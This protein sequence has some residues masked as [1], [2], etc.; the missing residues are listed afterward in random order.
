MA[1]RAWVR[2]HRRQWRHSGAVHGEFVDPEHGK[3]QEAVVWLHDGEV[4]QK[5]KKI[6]RKEA[7]KGATGI[8]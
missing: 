1:A 2:A 4:K 3:A 7:Q 6:G 5:R 8:E